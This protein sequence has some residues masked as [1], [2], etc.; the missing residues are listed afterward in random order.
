MEN[1]E[2]GSPLKLTGRHKRMNEYKRVNSPDDNCDHPT[3]RFID[4]ANE[5][6][7]SPTKTTH[8][9]CTHHMEVA[10]QLHFV[11]KSQK[12]HRH[13]N[14]EICSY[15]KDGTKCEAAAKDDFTYCP[16]HLRI[17]C[18]KHSRSEKLRRSRSG[19]RNED[20][21]FDHNYE[22]LLLNGP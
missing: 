7:L 20:F 10:A 22:D 21:N 17:I 12:R 1:S 14:V 9:Y 15:G 5:K 3:C 11:K 8:L 19:E 16:F 2:S 4:D 18:N 6:C 13:E